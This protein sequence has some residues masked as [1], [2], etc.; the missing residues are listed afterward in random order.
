MR[1]FGCPVTILNTLDSL[2]N[3]D[4]KVDEGFLVGYSVSSKAFRVFNSR[5]C[6]FQ[7]TLHKIFLENKPNV[8]D[9][10]AAFEVKEPEF[11]GRKPESEVHIS[12]SSIPAIRQIFTN[13]TNTFS[14]A[15][16]SNAVV[17]L[18]DSTYSDD[19]EDVGVE[20]DFT[21]LETSI[22][23]SDKDRAEA[24]IQAIDKMLKT[25]R[26]MR[27]LESDNLG[28]LQPKADIEIFIGYAP[29]KKAFRIYNRRTRRI[30]EIIHVDFDEL[31]AMASEHSSSGPALN[32]MTPGTISSGL[33]PTSSPSTSYVPPS[34]IN[35][36][37][38]FQP[39]FDELLN[40]PPSV[41]NQTP[42]AIAHIA[43]VIPPGYVD[44]SGSPSST[45]VEQDAPSTNQFPPGYNFMSKLSFV[46][47]IWRKWD[48]DRA[49]ALIQVIDKMLKT[50][51]IMRSLERCSTCL[52][53][54]GG[55]VIKIEQQQ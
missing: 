55:E 33:V 43:E 21:N 20:A 8:V 12:P 39:M 14:A 49:A 38:L 9:G 13:S 6:I 19:E 17:K 44:S 41:V 36:D 45:T 31:T 1:P 32:E 3:F 28:K 22:I 16:P 50:T 25:R 27:S 5:T 15:G 48:K 7:E 4:G 26:I 51:R 29:T 46:T 40:P 52:R 42:E 18:E 53:P 2:G 35:W 54:S 23:V 11:E 30:V 24:M 10:D 47:T 37:L 34:R